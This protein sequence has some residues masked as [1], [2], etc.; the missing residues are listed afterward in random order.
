MPHSILAIDPSLRRT[1]IAIGTTDSPELTTITTKLGGTLRLAYFR[2]AIESLLEGQPSVWMEGYS[3]ASKGSSVFGLGELGGV[4]RLACH[5][6]QVIP[7][8]VQPA[9]IKVYATGKGNASKDEVLAEAIRRFGYAGACND[10]A[11][12]LILY[13]LARAHYELPTVTLPKS[14]T[15][16]LEV[17]NA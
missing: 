2:D 8:V 1:G 7:N 16:A 9:T 4:I 5:D 6:F 10:E 14:H 17:L 12:A 13:H 11:D 3:Y 15:R